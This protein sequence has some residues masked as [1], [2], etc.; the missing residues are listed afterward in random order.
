MDLSKLKKLSQLV[1]A[2]FLATQ[3]QFRGIVAEETRL[4]SMLRDLDTQEQAGRIRIQSDPTIKSIGGDVTWHRWISMTRE[5]LNTQL[6]RVLAEKGRIQEV[7]QEK[8]GRSTV[9][10]KMVSEG[11]KKERQKT[12]L[13]ELQELNNH[14]VLTNCKD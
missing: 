5:R 2:D 4:R 14:F 3:S 8:G 11:R 6:A 10:D 9:V 1:E 7:F 12:R 13:A